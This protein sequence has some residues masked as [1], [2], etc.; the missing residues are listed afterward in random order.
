[1]KRSSCI[2]LV[3]PKFNDKWPHKGEMRQISQTEEKAMR[4]RGRETGVLWLPP[5]STGECHQPTETGRIFSPRA[6]QGAQTDLHLD[7]GLLDSEL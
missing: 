3:G 6:L 2:I 5:G 1:M 7:F 4:R